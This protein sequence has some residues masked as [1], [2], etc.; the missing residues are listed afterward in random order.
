VFTG[1]IRLDLQCKLHYGRNCI[2]N[3]GSF[4]LLGT[5]PEI[6]LHY[7][8][9]QF[10][11]IPFLPWLRSFCLYAVIQLNICLQVDNNLE[12]KMK[13]YNEKKTGLSEALGA[14]Q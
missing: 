9:K 13:H 12:R 7:I 2:Q 4:R 5:K 3:S 14:V 10:I 8:I 11:H 6:I 1:S